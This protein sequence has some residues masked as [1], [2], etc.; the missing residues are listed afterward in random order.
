V[1]FPK[2]IEE[3]ANCS[4]PEQDAELLAIYQSTENGK[5][6]LGYSLGFERPVVMIRNFSTLKIPFASLLIDVKKKLTELNIG[7]D[8]PEINKLSEIF[9]WNQNMVSLWIVSYFEFYKQFIEHDQIKVMP[10]KTQ[11]EYF[12]R[13]SSN[14]GEGNE[15]INRI[16]YLKFPIIFDIDKF[17]KYISDMVSFASKQK[18]VNFYDDFVPNDAYPK[19]FE[20]MFPHLNVEN[21]A[22]NQ[23][24]EI[25][26][27]KPASFSKRA[28]DFFYAL[29]AFSNYLCQSRIPQVYSSTRISVLKN[30]IINETKTNNTRPR[31]FYA[32]IPN[33]T[34]RLKDLQEF[35]CLNFKN[36]NIGQL[37]ESL[38]AYSDS[39]PGFFF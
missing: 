19:S 35:L 11:W 4:N 10:I 39:R 16:F 18:F 26:H 22:S 32:F 37:N 38:K 2:K 33:Q 1:I 21:L 36:V 23:W 13:V 9:Q 15:C 8:Y 27:S 6:K 28:T 25:I 5:T 7:S 14:G 34:L 12:L 24:S 20:G 30:L 31:K 3:I 17:N 29:V